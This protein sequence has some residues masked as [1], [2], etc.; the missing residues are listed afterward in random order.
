L[1]TVP[2]ER[3]SSPERD[4]AKR[5]DDPVRI[6]TITSV[7]GPAVSGIYIQFSRGNLD[8]DRGPSAAAWV[9]SA[10]T[11]A[12]SD[13]V[14]EVSQGPFYGAVV[15][16]GLL[17][18][19]GI[20]R[21]SDDRNILMLVGAAWLSD[22]D[23]RL[24]TPEEAW[25]ALAAA[26]FPP[27]PA[28]KGNYLLALYDAE[29]RRLIIE[30]DRFGVIPFYYRTLPDG[31]RAGSE[32]KFASAPPPQSACLPAVAEMLRFGYLITHHTIVDGVLRLPPNHRL[33]CQ[34]G[35]IDIEPLPPPLFARD[36][37]ADA[38]FLA[39][40]TCA[41]ENNLARYR[42]DVKRVSLAL[43]GGLDSR[44]VALAA[45]RQG[46][47]VH[48][49]ST[50]EPGSL[51]CRVAAAFADNTGI[52]CSRRP[53]HGEDLPDWFDRAIW[54]TEGRCPPEHMHF[55]AGGLAADE[56][57]GPQ[58][59]GLIGDIVVGG[60][61][62]DPSLEK[63]GPDAIRSAC[64]SLMRGIVYWPGDSRQSALAPEL[65]R[66][67]AASRERVAA[68]L[69]GEET[70][71]GSYADYLRFRYALRLHGFIIPCLTGQVLPWTDIITPYLDPAFC[72]LCASLRTADI[73][74]REAQL[75][76]GQLHYEDFARVP[77]VKDGVLLPVLAGSPDA[78]E[79]GWR[80]LQRKKR[81]RYLLCR[82]SR[83]RINL[84][85]TESYPAYG[86]WYR[87]WPR[88]RRYI[89]DVLLAERSLDRGLWRREG[90]RRLMHDLRIG[91]NAWAALSTI[92]ACE[93]L[94]R[95]F[96]EGHERPTGFP[97]SLRYSE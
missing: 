32:I 97:A 9:K 41:F 18:S 84:P 73:A 51:E 48:A 7:P 76:W 22:E 45:Q 1:R 42:P 86:Q 55:L 8:P 83:G 21:T 60:D 89:A 96:V 94:L 58:L 40:L 31:M 50:G 57:S 44:L 47:E 56:L 4:R 12:V 19:G 79:R 52:P 66:L 92:L 25:R 54:S 14:D 26:G 77:R 67:V 17:R 72:D 23:S 81:A 20:Y 70:F 78:Y 3:F 87:R 68:G 59:H 95:Q 27:G 49:F 33:R 91:R 2:F 5:F 82:L 34:D 28:L 13:A 53:I 71:Q 61:L 65:G 16:H 24:I 64:L 74:E 69:L 63:Q 15:H 35:K 10:T 62:D 36:R 38:D 88:V 30:N 11:R 75:R 85:E 90:V 37:P 6:R 39:R 29:S 46:L 93:I 80:K 43:S